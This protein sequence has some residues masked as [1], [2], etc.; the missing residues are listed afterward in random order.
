MHSEKCLLDHFFFLARHR[1]RVE[2][3]FLTVGIHNT[4]SLELEHSEQVLGCTKV[5]Y[6]VPQFAEKKAEKAEK[7][8]GFY[9]S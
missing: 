9:F 7:L 2:I 4:M 3:R 5:L 6:F 1:L 8:K